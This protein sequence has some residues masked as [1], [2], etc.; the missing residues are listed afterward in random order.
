MWWFPTEYHS[1]NLKFML[2]S[3]GTHPVSY[4]LKIKVKR[5]SVVRNASTT[6]TIEAIL[7]FLIDICFINWKKYKLFTGNKCR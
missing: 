1:F 5:L 2:R 7:L 3:L 6:N 4:A